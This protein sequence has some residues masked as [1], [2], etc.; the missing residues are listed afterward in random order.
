MTRTEAARAAKIGRPEQYR[1]LTQ[2]GH[3][4]SAEVT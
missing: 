3:R 1:V 4:A 2:A